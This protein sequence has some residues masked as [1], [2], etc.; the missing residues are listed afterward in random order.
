MKIVV[1]LML[2]ASAL[3]VAGCSQL[4]GA[5]LG[6]TFTAEPFLAADHGGAGFSG[7]LA[8]EYTELGRAQAG[9]TRWMNATAYIAKVREAEAGGTPAPWAPSELGVNGEAAA[10]YDEVVAK[11]GAN[12]AERPEA[13]ARAQA[14]WDQYLFALRA[15]GNGAKCPL[16]SEDALAML[17]E[18]LAACDPAVD[19]AS[20]FVVYF[21]FNRTDL[22]SRALATLDDVAE[23]YQATDPSAVSVVGHADTV[24]SVEYNQTLSE[25]RARSVAGAL[26]GRGIPRGAMTLAGRSELEPARVTG[27]GVR[28]PLNRRVEISLSE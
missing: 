19:M 26:E 24:G 18:A 12:R 28:E 4:P 23:A 22:T 15:E 27:D 21:G 17:N 3:A 6:S 2:G 20:D 9:M 8:S 13:C 25:N 7:A 10:L 16:S 5:S 14:M 11:I 1:R